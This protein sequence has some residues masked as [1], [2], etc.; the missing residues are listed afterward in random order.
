MGGVEGGEDGVV[1]GERNPKGEGG[2]RGVKV[3]VK[4]VA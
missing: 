1:D 3:D 4:V 2:V